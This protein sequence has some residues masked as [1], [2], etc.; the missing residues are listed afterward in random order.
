LAQLYKEIDRQGLTRYVIGFIPSG[1]ISD[2]GGG[3]L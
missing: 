1:A 3:L 2:L